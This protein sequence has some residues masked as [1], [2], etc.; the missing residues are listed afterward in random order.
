MIFG[1]H[2]RTDNSP[3]RNREREYEFLNRSARPEMIRV[4]ELIE[5][6][7]Q[8]YPEEEIGELISRLQSND[9]THFRSSIFE[10]FLHEVLLRMGC[11]LSPHPELENGLS[12]RPDFL[13]RTP[14]GFEFYLE[15]VLASEANEDDAGAEARK[16]V[17]M[18][19]LTSNPHH[20]FMVDIDDDGNPSTQPSGKKL[21]RQ[22][23]GW[24]DTLDPD[25]V[26]ELI[27]NQGFD[28]V[29]R[30]SWSHED[31][32][33][34]FRPIPIKHE[35]RGKSK[36]LIGIGS[37]GGGFVDAWSPIRDAVKYKGS[38]YGETEKALLVA[39]N[40]DRFHLDRIDEMQALFGQEQF[41]FK[42]GQVEAEPTFQRAPNGA[43]YGK[44]GP[45]Y[46]R[47]SGL[48]IFS[49]LSPYT[50][51]RIHPTLYFNPWAAY[52]LPEQLKSFEYASPEEGKMVWSQGA[53]FAQIFEVNEDWPE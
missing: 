29:P 39:V 18:D 15:A 52:E 22:L 34:I 53:T 27:E 7:A 1:N 16:G 5:S 25:E 20:N 11:V 41:V 4:R 23:H 17:V 14:E 28:S 49:D 30:F 42:I 12:Y 36:T 19:A 35:R 8:N 21:V 43:W 46:T 44:S 50:I 10:L 13:V 26:I 33:V 40:M 51:G 3:K 38:K 48:W 37:T 6:A 31:W 47:V 45:Q 2:Q 24:L 32:K 9:D